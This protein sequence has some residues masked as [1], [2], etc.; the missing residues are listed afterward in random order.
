M[1]IKKDEMLMM[2]GNK[3]ELLSDMLAIVYSC[4]RQFNIPK[5]VL[6]GMIAESLVNIKD[7]AI[8]K[9]FDLSE[10]EPKAVK[11]PDNFPS[12]EF[13]KFCGCENEDEYWDSYRQKMR[14]RGMSEEEVE[15]GLD[16]LK[17]TFK[18]PKSD[19]RSEEETKTDRDLFRGMFGD[20][21]NE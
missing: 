13:F 21:L 12:E 7:D 19:K 9:T 4:H 2:K 3:D 1:I 8:I 11:F 15:K 17:K 10:E 20:L 16:F 18:F 5:E 14:D 6:A